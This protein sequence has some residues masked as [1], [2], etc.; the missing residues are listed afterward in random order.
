MSDA[1]SISASNIRLRF[2]S[3]IKG[4]DQ[5]LDCGNYESRTTTLIA[6]ALSEVPVTTLTTQDPVKI[7]V[8]IN[9]PADAV[10]GIYTGTIQVKSAN[11]VKQKFNLELL[12]SILI[13][14]SSLSN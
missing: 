7:W 11:E 2:P 5:A 14:G 13:Y 8:T 6:D 10:P 9:T 4:D 3:Y 12:V 1:N